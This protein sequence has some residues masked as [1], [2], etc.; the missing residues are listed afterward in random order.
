MHEIEE[1]VK[2]IE[3]TLKGLSRIEKILKEVDGNE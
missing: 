3:N 1:L 2:N